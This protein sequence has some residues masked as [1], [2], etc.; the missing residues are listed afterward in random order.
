M[1]S[2]QTPADSF[3]LDRSLPITARFATTDN[4][5]NLYLISPENA[6]EKYAPDNQLLA[7]YSN[8]RLGAAASIDVTN[9]LKILVWYADFRTLVFLDRT[10]NQLGELNLISAGY[11]EVRSVATAADGNLW[12][13]DEVAF[14]LKKITPGGETRF[15]SPAL[16]QLLNG[17]INISAIRDN[18]NEVLATD[19]EQGILWFDVYAQYQR[20]LPRKNISSFAL[21]AKHL[22]YLAGTNLHLEQ[23]H[24]F[25]SRE[26]L[27]PATALQPTAKYWLSTGCLLVQNGEQLEVWVW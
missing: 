7:R 20:S 14:Q 12:L 2:A 1:L 23:L 9:P 26:I 8:N 21:G 11:P 4:L 18:G 25:A 10:L 13:Y 16:N 15:E 27:L 6:L 3:H 22:G 17:R 24:A 5:G 19:P